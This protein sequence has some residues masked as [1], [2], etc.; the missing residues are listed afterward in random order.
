MLGC[1]RPAMETTIVP[2]IDSA[3]L[4]STC[5]PGH[6]L[7]EGPP[8]LKMAPVRTP[9]LLASTVELLH[10]AS[11]KMPQASMATDRTRIP[12]IVA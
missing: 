4:P 6:P 3:A 7:F 8:Q 12:A 10:P 2:E 9:V 11:I 5:A 1:D